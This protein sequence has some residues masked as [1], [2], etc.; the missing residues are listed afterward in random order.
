[1]NIK[2]C[3]GIF[4]CLV[5]DIIFALKPSSVHKFIIKIRVVLKSHTLNYKN[6]I[7]RGTFLYLLLYIQTFPVN[8]V[9]L[10]K[11]KI[12]SL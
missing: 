10:I 2:S 9:M 7:E 6:K 11:T 8:N 5:I 1:M 12:I 3:V 4:L